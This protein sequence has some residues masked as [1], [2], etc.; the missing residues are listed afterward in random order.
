MR[1]F[2]RSLKNDYKT[3]N[4]LQNDLQSFT[5][6]GGHRLIIT[7]HFSL[8]GVY[9]GLPPFSITWRKIVIGI[10]NKI[11][12]IKSDLKYYQTW[13]NASWH[14]YLVIE[15]INKI[16]LDTVSKLDECVYSKVT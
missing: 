3:L 1:C 11:D 16:N 10:W 13:L 8:I 7:S 9:D 14:N 12:C 2:P 4:R 6:F 15:E 5:D